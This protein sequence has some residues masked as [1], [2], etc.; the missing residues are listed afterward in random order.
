MR[1]NQVPIHNADA[2][3]LAQRAATY[4]PGLRTSFLQADAQEFASM[5][6]VTIVR[7]SRLQIVAVKRSKDVFEFR[8]P[9]LRA[10]AAG[11]KTDPVV[12]RQIRELGS[13]KRLWGRKLA[14]MILAAANASPEIKTA[15]V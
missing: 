7:E 9:T 13:G 2:A 11:D 1:S 15:A 6:S 5:F 3:T 12:A 4:A 8:L 14:A 10:Y